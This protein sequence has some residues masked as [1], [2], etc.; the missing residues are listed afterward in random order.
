[1]TAEG[2]LRIQSHNVQGV[3]HWFHLSGLETQLGVLP[4]LL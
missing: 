2:G 1:M 3:A 4:Y